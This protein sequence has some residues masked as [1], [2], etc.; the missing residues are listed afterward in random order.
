MR[1]KE[2]S[3]SNAEALVARRAQQQHLRRRNRF[4]RKIIES[5]SMSSGNNNVSLPSPFLIKDEIEILTPR[6]DMTATLYLSADDVA[7]LFSFNLY[8]YTVAPLTLSHALVFKDF[9]EGL[10]PQNFS[11]KSPLLL[12]RVE[13]SVRRSF[14]LGVFILS[15]VLTTVWLEVVEGLPCCMPNPEKQHRAEILKQ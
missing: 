5:F 15:V 11:G 4:G 12:L 2:R 13:R 9:I 14:V 10:G 7:F 8:F 1:K 3:T 6:A